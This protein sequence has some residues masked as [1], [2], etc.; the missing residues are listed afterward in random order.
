MNPTKL[1]T[2]QTRSITTPCTA[3]PD[4]LQHIE[5][6]VKPPPRRPDTKHRQRTQQRIRRD[7]ILVLTTREHLQLTRPSVLVD[8]ERHVERHAEPEQAT[9]P[10]VCPV[11]L[12]VA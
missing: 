10:A 9:G 12:L 11:E 2:L 7:P 4:S 1:A 5:N 8:P 3:T 6:L